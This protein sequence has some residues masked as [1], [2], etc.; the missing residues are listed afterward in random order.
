MKDMN[1]V[2]EHLENIYNQLGRELDYYQY[3]DNVGELV[4]IRNHL[5][6]CL[7]H[8]ERLMNSEKSGETK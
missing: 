8:M 5:E 1:K 2:L 4:E 6:Y 7:E 3:K